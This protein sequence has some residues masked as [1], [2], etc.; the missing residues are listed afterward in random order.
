MCNKPHLILKVDEELGVI[1]KQNQSH[2]AEWGFH[3]KL[4]QLELGRKKK[5]VSLL[6]L[7]RRLGF[8]IIKHLPNLG[9]KHFLFLF[10]FFF[11]LFVL[12]CFL[13]T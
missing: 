6:E 2:E 12:K 3:Y 5:W 1:K 13:K 4:W 9:A 7:L 8:Q 10:L 11:C